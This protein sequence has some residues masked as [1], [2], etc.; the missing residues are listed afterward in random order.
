MIELTVYGVA[1]PQGNK[2]A[3]VRG[4]KAVLTEGRRPESRAAFAS[5]RQAVATAARDWQEAN[6][7]ALLDE[8]L[9]VSIAFWLPRPPSIPKK[10]QW[11][12]R[13]P[14]LDKLVRSVL[15]AVTGVR[16]SDDSRVVA[17]AASKHYVHDFPPHAI[18]AISPRDAA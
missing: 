1:Q 10:R 16:I 9:A 7:A 11:P 13:K 17:L 4:G 15:D 18:I 8:P 6:Q 2:T 12:D 14:D 5:W 3:F